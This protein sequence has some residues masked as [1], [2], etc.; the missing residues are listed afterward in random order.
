MA[1][2]PVI[3]PPDGL[4]QQVRDQLTAYRTVSEQTVTVAIPEVAS[5]TFESAFELLPIT[6][7]RSGEWSVIGIAVLSRRESPKR[8]PTHALLALGRGLAGD[9]TELRE[10]K[11]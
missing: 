11:G 8:I 2:F 3:P 1:T 5:S 6:A 7:E 10:A 4:E 9:G